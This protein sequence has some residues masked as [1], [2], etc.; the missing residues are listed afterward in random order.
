MLI[1]S[2]RYGQTNCFVGPT[3]KYGLFDVDGT[4][5]F[6]CTYRAARNMAFQNV[7]KVRGQV[8]QLYEF[9]GSEIVGTKVHP[10]FGIYPEVY[11]LPMESAIAT[12]VVSLIWKI[13]L[14]IFLAG[15]RYHYFRSLRLTR[16]LSNPRRST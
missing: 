16:R 9:D 1:E 11:V 5:L 2:P 3:I 14:L 13:L 7:A 4:D 10:P 8:N 12:K 6:I 15:H